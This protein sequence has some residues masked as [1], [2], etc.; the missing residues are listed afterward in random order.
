MQSVGDD[1]LTRALSRANAMRAMESSYTANQQQ[2][3]PQQAQIQSKSVARS[4]GMIVKVL[5]KK[6]VTSLQGKALFVDNSK[7]QG[8]AQSSSAR[9]KKRI[10]RQVRLSNKRMKADGLASLVTGLRSD[11]VALLQSAWN[12]YAKTAILKSTATDMQIQSR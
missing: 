5:G 12:E 11:D 8:Q 3:E 1:S 9:G 7:T 4:L 2:P 6:T 10:Q